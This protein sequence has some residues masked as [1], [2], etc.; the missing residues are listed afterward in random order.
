MPFGPGTCSIT[1]LLLPEKTRHHIR[2]YQI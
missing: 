2:S 1:W